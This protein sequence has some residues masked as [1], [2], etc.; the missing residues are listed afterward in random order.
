MILNTHNRGTKPFSEIGIGEMFVY[1][2]DA[3]D[4]TSKPKMAIG[5]KIWVNNDVSYNMVDVYNGY[6]YTMGEDTLVL[7]LHEVELNYEF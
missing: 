7:P 5:L 3:I 2:L 6:A 1:T 4:K